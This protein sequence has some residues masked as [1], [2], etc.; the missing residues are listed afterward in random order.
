METDEVFGYKN[1]PYCH[2]GINIREMKME[3]PH[4]TLEGLQYTYHFLKVLENIECT[5]ICKVK[6][7]ESHTR[8]IKYAID[9][10]ALI[11]L[12][13]ILISIGKHQEFLLYII[14]QGGGRTKR[15]TLASQWDQLT[16]YM[17]TI[18]SQT[19][20]IKYTT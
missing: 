5:L 17:V 2:D 10:N 9:N 8:S 11:N 18:S 4:S 1:Y 15:I 20:I 14:T 3:M 12:Y 13:I 19:M 7:K 16:Q 6:L